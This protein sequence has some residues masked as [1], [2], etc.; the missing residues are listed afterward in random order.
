M[1]TSHGSLRHIYCNKKKQE[2][3]ARGSLGIVL[4][5]LKMLE[6]KSGTGSLKSYRVF[7][8]FTLWAKCRFSGQKCSF[9]AQNPFFPKSSTFFC[10]HHDWTPKRQHFCVDPV[11]RRASG[12]PRGP[13]FGRKRPKSGPEAEKRPP[14]WPN[15]HLPENRSYPELPQD[16]GDL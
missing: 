6:F 1:C 12:R 13:I 3:C 16:M 5:I 7:C 15:G 11:A 14:E 8:I 4:N 9:W 10:H 2:H